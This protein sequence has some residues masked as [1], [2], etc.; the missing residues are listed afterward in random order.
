VAIAAAASVAPAS[1]A[2]RGDPSPGARRASRFGRTLSVAAI[3]AWVLVPADHLLRRTFTLPAG[4]RLIAEDEGIEGSVV[5]AEDRSGSRRLY[6][7]AFPMSATSPYAQRYMR[8]FVHVPLLSLER[9]RAALVICF[10]VGNTASA[11]TLYPSL[12]HIDIADLSEVVLRHAEDFRATNLGVLDDPRTRVF[13]NDGRQ[14]LR[15]TAEG[16]YDLV[17][18]EPPPIGDA[19]VSSLYTKEFYEL[20]RSRL[21]PD[22]FVTQWLPIYQ[23]DGEVGRALVRTFI[24][25]FPGAVLLSGEQSEL[26]LVGRRE[27]APRIDLDDFERRLAAL[28]RVA[29]DLAAI[30]MRDPVELVGT[31]TCGGTDL[32]AAVASASPMTDDR[33]VLE[34]AST[35]PWAP[36]R[37][38]SALFQL[39]GVRDFCPSCFHD[40]EPVAAVARLPEYLRVMDALYR[41]PAFL[42][43]DAG[44]SGPQ[45]Y[46]RLVWEDARAGETISRHGYLR[47]VLG[48]VLTGSQN[49]PL[50]PI[51]DRASLRA[52]VEADPRDAVARLELGIAHLARR[53]LEDAA[54]SL[55][56]AVRVDERLVPARFALGFVLLQQGRLPDAIEQYTRGI[57]LAPGNI[58]ARMTL[59]V[60]QQHTGRPAE[61]IAELE[62]V[63]ALDPTH[64]EAHAILCA[65]YRGNGDARASAHCE[66]AKAADPGTQ[67]R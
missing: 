46:P 1:R 23:V 58:E 45:P 49:P 51:E 34:Y 30:G 57:E 63:T 47:R 36:S 53:S 35:S 5:V 6:T 17:T 37:I 52:R 66:R 7:N 14:H 32:A 54:S 60:L 61:A 55:R 15:M 12:E 9:P 11:M 65:L 67:R 42:R 62:A 24:D 4:E 50:A 43:A 19:G 39:R 28:P 26:I 44:H 2:R 64:A 59:A 41:D 18:L 3:G 22:G 25:V 33:P 56:D 27:G 10:G 16:T 13:V 29:S 48:S 31:F 38:P 40:G 8:A 20:A 21:S